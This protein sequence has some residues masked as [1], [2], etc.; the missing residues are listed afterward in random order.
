MLE[1]RQASF[2][3]ALEE[4]TGMLLAESTEPNILKFAKKI[5]SALYKQKQLKGSKNLDKMKD[6]QKDA[7]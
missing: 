3:D 2:A 5:I 1:Y 7:L 6:M 4:A